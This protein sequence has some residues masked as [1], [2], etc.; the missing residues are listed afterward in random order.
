MINPRELL[1]ALFSYGGPRNLDPDNAPFVAL[2]DSLSVHSLLR[3]RNR[4]PR[5]VQSVTV[6]TPA[7]FVGYCKQYG[8][9]DSHV[10]IGG[11]NPLAISAVL[12]HHADS[13]ADGAQWGDHVVNLATS[14][15]PEYK[16]WSGANKKWFDQLDFADFLQDHI[17]DVIQPAAGDLLS[18]VL[19]FQDK[20]NTTVSSAVN[21]LNGSVQ[22]TLDEQAEGQNGRTLIAVPRE[23][24]VQFQPYQFHDGV[25]ALTGLFGYRVRDGK[26]TM[27]VRFPTFEQD[28]TEFD[29]DIIDNQIIPPLMVNDITKVTHG[30]I[31]GTPHNQL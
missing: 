28:M 29:R 24:I 1:A 13:N 11:V 4:P 16:A 8:T 17:S 20:R 9:K 30:K 5:V 27:Q 10:Y 18:L 19:N 3:H 6:N 14:T 22:F 15:T 12:N 2:P 21:L 7:S 26:L 31:V 25:I 23:I